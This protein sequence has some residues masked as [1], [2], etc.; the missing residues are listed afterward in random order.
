MNIIVFRNKTSLT[1]PISLSRS[2]STFSLFLWTTLIEIAVWSL[3]S[4]VETCNSFVVSN[5][6]P[7]HSL[8]PHKL[9]D[10]R[11]K[12]TEDNVKQSY[13]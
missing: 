12:K 11:Q 2:H 8:L 1:F 10:I 5:Q 4:D 9:T 3:N 13:S 6:Y 7:V